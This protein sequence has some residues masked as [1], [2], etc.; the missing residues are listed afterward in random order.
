MNQRL[1]IGI[2][3]LDVAWRRLIHQLGIWVEEVDYSKELATNYSVII[4]NKK[5]DDQQK[6]SL[7]EYLE[8]QGSLLEMGVHAVFTPKRNTTSAYSTFLVNDEADSIFAHVPYVDVYAP[9]RLHSSQRFYGGLIDIQSSREHNLAFF[10][11]PITA[12]MQDRRYHRKRFFSPHHPFPDEIVSKVSKD[13]L[14]ELFRTVLKELH[15]KREL[16]FIEKWASPTPKPAF[17]FRIDSDF[18]DKQSVISLY[19]VLQRNEIPATWFLH[20]EAHEEW[21]DL[22]QD[23]KHQEIALHG[24]EHGTSSSHKKTQQNIQKGKQLLE[25]AGFTPTGFTAPYGIW[26]AAL[27]KSLESFSFKY[28]SEFTFYFDGLPLQPENEQLP[29]QVPVHPICTG[30]LSRKRYS[31]DEMLAY[32]KF[33]LQNKRARYQPAFLYHHPLQPGLSVFDELFKNVYKMKF[34]PLNLHQFA[35]FWESRNAFSFTARMQD[36]R[37]FIE[38]SSDA[39]KYLQVST[40]HH[41][42]H[43]VQTSEDVVNLTNSTKFEYSKPYLPNPEQVKELKSNRF[44]LLKTSLLDWNNRIRL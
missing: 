6:V 15:F 31:A 7:K 30:S 9:V 20:V 39:S 26:N 3:N 24:Y 21:L 38:D 5:P 40:G 19:E 35:Q 10:G 13:S 16:P 2:Q 28:T 8:Q 14:S 36:G 27:R 33:V 32:F 4:L 42:F 43:L 18:G 34:E 12:L 17:S 1:C 44:S 41:Q 23:F 29:I 22:F 11:A 25:Q 37:V